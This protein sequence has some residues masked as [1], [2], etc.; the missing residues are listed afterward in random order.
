ML[1][2][3]AKCAR[4]RDGVDQP[5][6]VRVPEPNAAIGRDRDEDGHAHQRA[7]GVEEGE[8]LHRVRES[9]TARHRDA[10][11]TL[12]GGVWAGCQTEFQNARNNIPRKDRAIVRSG[13]EE[14]GRREGNA[15][16]IVSVPVQPARRMVCVSIR[17]E[18]DLVAPPYRH[19]KVDGALRDVFNRLNLCSPFARKSLRP[20]HRRTRTEHDRWLGFRR[21]A[22]TAGRARRSRLPRHR[23]AHLLLR[24]SVLVVRPLC[25]ERDGAEKLSR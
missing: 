8:R 7:R 24:G 19:V 9:P 23:E 14:R 16:H 2:R 6:R 4:A 21:R 15:E 25:V 5:A 10:V 1:Q 13:T 3:L 20:L 18:H 22:G 17:P 11:V 12:S